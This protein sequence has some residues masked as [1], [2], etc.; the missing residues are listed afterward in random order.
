MNFQANIIEEVVVNYVNSSTDCHIAKGCC[1]YGVSDVYGIPTKVCHVPYELI[2]FNK[3]IRL[4]AILP[5]WR[6]DSNCPSE[7]A[8][9]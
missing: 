6:V 2:V 3:D 5:I 9:V 8:N 7:S 4:H 1:H